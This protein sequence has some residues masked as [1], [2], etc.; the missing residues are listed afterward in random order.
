VTLR[1]PVS[2]E[3]EE[4]DARR[5][6]DAAVA[7]RLLARL[8]LSVLDEAIAPEDGP[9]STTEALLRLCWRLLEPALPAGA[10]WRLWIEETPNNI[11]ETDRE[12]MLRAPRDAGAMRGAK[13]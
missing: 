3:T 10:L 2:P 1:G 12:E 5:G 4:L 6:L 13:R 8:D 11:V 9:T 7:D